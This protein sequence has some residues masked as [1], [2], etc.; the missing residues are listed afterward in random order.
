MLAARRAARWS[1]GRRRVALHRGRQRRGR[2]CLAGRRRGG[3]VV[4]HA[5]VKPAGEAAGV[6]MDVDTVGVA[7]TVVE[8]AG[9]V[10]TGVVVAGVEAPAV[11]APRIVAT[12]VETTGVVSTD[13]DAAGVNATAD[14]TDE[15][16]R[17]RQGRS[18]E[19]AAPANKVWATAA[20]VTADGNRNGDHGNTGCGVGGRD[21]HG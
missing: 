15:D 16:G 7:A 11:N 5:F 6:A 21:C 2:R 3:D 19:A 17:P 4:A 1:G 13:T 8:A 20:K 12:G 9:V 10:A 18:T 14:G